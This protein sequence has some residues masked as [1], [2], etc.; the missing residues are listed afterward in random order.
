[1][2]LK[3]FLSPNPFIL[4][5]IS[6]ILGL[7]VG[8]ICIAAIGADP[9]SG[10]GNL[11]WG[12]IKNTERIGNT[13]ARATTLIFTGL[14]V[15]YAF[16]TGLFN[17]GAAGQM[18]AGGITSTA[19]GLFV[20]LPPYLLLPLM[21]IVAILAGGL[22]GFI[23]GILKAVFNVHEVVATIMMNW[24]AYW[25]VNFIV[26]M[27]MKGTYLETESMILPSSSTLRIPALTEFT[28]GSSVNLGIILALLAV[29]GIA[30]VL[31]KTTLGFELKAVGFN[32]D[33]AE[34]AGIKVNKSIALSMVIA[35]ALAG[36]GGLTFYAGY[37]TSIQ[38]GVLPSQGFDG[39]AI[40]LLGANNPYG[41]FLSAIFIAIMHEG[42]GLMG[43]LTGIPPQIADTIVAVIIYFAA[44][45]LLIEQV[46]KRAAKR[47]C[48]GQQVVDD[49]NA[50][51]IEDAS[52][53]KE[54]N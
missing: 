33:G 4:S 1:M 22:W 26:P 30:I 19:V 40:A 42:K 14:S 16:R 2:N 11:F 25:S 7:I 44:I 24:I 38:I 48:K 49:A 9:I 17:I 52:P 12:G 51:D 8:A 28:N 27:Y 20:P 34:Y 47:L 37:S 36:L 13:I 21:I 15:A 23:P 46:W 6:I 29:V 41:T 5:C 39:I 53:A 50:V 43:A 18:L 10:L 54:E 45:S 35:G 32:R 3:K 31:D